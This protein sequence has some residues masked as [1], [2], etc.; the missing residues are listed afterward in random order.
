MTV[1]TD[2]AR[3]RLSDRLQY[4]AARAAARLPGWAQRLLSGRRAIVVDG[5]TLEPQ[6]QLIRALHRL[7]GAPGLVEPTVAK[8]RARFRRQMLSLAGPKTEVGAVRDFQADGAGGPIRMRHYA[9]PAAEANG[10]P[11][12]MLVFL[13]GGGF[14]IGDL[15]THDEPCRIL[16]R[17]AGTH[18]LS[19]EYRLAPE[20]PFPAALEDARRAFDFARDA[21]G[22]LGADPARVSIGGDSAGGNLATVV[23]RTRA[24]EG[25]APA[26]QLLIYP[27]TDS[28]AMHRRSRD[29]FGRGFFLTGRDRDSFSRYYLEG[30]GVDGS[31]PRVSPLCAADL[32]ELPPALVVTA[33]FDLLR[34]EG[35]AYAEALRAAGNTVRAYREP[36]LAHGFINL[37]GICPAARRATIGIARVWREMLVARG[38]ARGVA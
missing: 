6:L 25:L 33:G 27:V 16:C 9:P 32:A 26:A 18:V 14:V 23:A 15:D 13:H 4:V 38:V 10:D 11:A 17:H 34:D 2:G 37:T 31:D 36:A 7:H 1:P 24:R 30:S 12:P 5:Q 3:V 20:H 19:V 8:A 35:E 29:L 21:A 22:G 28:A